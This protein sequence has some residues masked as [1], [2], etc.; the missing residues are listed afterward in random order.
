V[1]GIFDAIQAAGGGQQRKN[2]SKIYLVMETKYT[3]LVS[4]V[5]EPMITHLFGHGLRHRKGKESSMKS[6]AEL[7]QELRQQILSLSGVTEKQNAGIHE[8]AFFVGRTMFMHIHGRSH[9]DI[10]LSKDDQ[11]QALAEGKARP[12]RWAPEKG[13]VTF[14][15]GDENDLAP[16]MDLIRRSHHHFAG[17]QPG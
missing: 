12:H 1:A 8:D 6:R 14:V 4:R 10:R 9:C 5:K 2:Q 11:A 13:Y 16:A 7:H 3:R 15:A 17:E